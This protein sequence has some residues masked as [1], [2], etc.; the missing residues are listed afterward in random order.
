MI[1]YFRSINIVNRVR[2]FYKSLLLNNS[3]GLKRFHKSAIILIIGWNVLCSGGDV[4]KELRVSVDLDVG[5][6]QNIKLINGKTVEIKL[7]DVVE[8]YDKFNLA[9][10]S[11]KARVSVNG[12]DVWLNSA[13]YNLPVTAGDVQIDC[14]ITK[15]YLEKSRRNAWG[16]LKDARFR[17]WPADSPFVKSGTFVYPIKQRW[18]ASETQMSNEPVFVDGGER[19]DKESIYYHSGLDF[20]GS[21]EMDKVVSATDGLVI[22]AGRDSLPGYE[23]TPGKPAYDAVW[24]LDERGWFIGYYHLFSIDSAVK[25]GARISMG[26]KIGRL[27]KEGSS[28]GWAHLHFQ[29]RCKQPSGEWGDEDG[30]AFLW[31]SYIRQYNPSVIA[32]ARPHQVAAVGQ[33]IMLDG[34]KSKSVKGEI[35]TYEWTLTDGTTASGPTAE[36]VYTKPGTY[37]EVLKV[38]NSDGSI[39]YDFAH[40]QVIDKKHPDKISPAIHANYHPTNNIKAGDAVTFKVRTFRTESGSEVWDFGDGSPPVNVKSVIPKKRIAGKY[41]ETIHSYEKAGHYIVKVKRT[42][43]YGYEATAHLHVEVLP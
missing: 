41:A 32:V 9:I 2:S 20:G 10:R 27:G 31:E 35:T 21:E 39:D 15:G 17:L 3:K 40:V 13:N 36:Q 1:M 23:D 26:Q 8:K 28:G 14:P 5:E 38:V 16:L 42:G 37:S 19:P 25:P 29:I 7:I 6:V 12:Q 34:R 11:A 33:T 43:E 22:T 18:F 4:D 24:I 30:Y